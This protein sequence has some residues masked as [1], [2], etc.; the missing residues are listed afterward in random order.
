MTPDDVLLGLA[1]WRLNGSEVDGHGRGSDT[2]FATEECV[3]F[4]KPA[5]DGSN[6]SGGVLKPRNRLA[7]LNALERLAEKIIGTGA[8]RRDDQIAFG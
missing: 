7:E 6:L 5:G 4:A 3:D 2:A 8:Q 1:A